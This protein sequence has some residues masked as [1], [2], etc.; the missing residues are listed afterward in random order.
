M[1]RAVDML[2]KVLNF[3]NNLFVQRPVVDP[4]EAALDR[5]FEKMNNRRLR[6]LSNI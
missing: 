4:R 1:Y 3:L 2:K 6:N 5:A